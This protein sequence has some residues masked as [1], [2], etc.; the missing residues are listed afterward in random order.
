MAS[1]FAALS[2]D[3]ELRTQLAH[4]AGAVIDAF[5]DLTISYRVAKANVHG[6]SLGFGGSTLLMSILKVNAIAN[7]SHSSYSSVLTHASKSMGTI[8]DDEKQSPSTLGLVL[9]VHAALLTMVMNAP[10]QPSPKTPSV[11]RIHMIAPPE[12]LPVT[13]QATSNVRQ[14]T[15]RQETRP[16]PVERT[17]LQPAT[18]PRA[19]AA[20]EAADVTPPVPSPPVSTSAD[21]A[22]L[23]ASASSPSAPSTSAARDA[24]PASALP[25]FDA[26]YLRNPAPAYPPLSRRLREQGKVL[27]RVVVRAD[28][29][30]DCVEL[31]R[32]S[33]S[34][35]LDEA[36]LEAVR[37]WRFV[38][39][40]NGET[41]IT[42]TVI[43]PIVFSLDS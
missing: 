40:R 29:L 3:L 22:N 13:Q 6:A 17:S 15:A 9:V 36:A 41:P 38:P 10:V 28:G 33:G 26:D 25:R 12:P 1:A 14:R 8:K 43:V 35:R 42:A 21:A 5:M 19:I 11:L 18:S 30:P 39:A 27:L 16:K 31:R 37:T 20:P 7:H 24:Q 32:S 2:A 4:R 23:A 34:A